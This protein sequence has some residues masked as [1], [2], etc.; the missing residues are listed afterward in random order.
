MFE[1]E[2]R[3]FKSQ[4]EVK[5]EVRHICVLVP[6]IKNLLSQKAFFYVIANLYCKW[7]HLTFDETIDMA[8]LE[9]VVECRTMIEM[10]K[11]YKVMTIR[12]DPL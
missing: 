2:S 5:E 9:L 10:R 3:I 8:H 7:N 1:S 12:Q 4:F 11:T 6:I